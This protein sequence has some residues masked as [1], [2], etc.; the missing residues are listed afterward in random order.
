MRAPTDGACDVFDLHLRHFRPITILDCVDRTEQESGHC[1]DVAELRSE[2]AQVRRDL[3]AL[4]EGV[5]RIEG[6]LTGPWRPTN[7]SPAPASKTPAEAAA[8]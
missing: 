7:G 8:E 2:P 5:A 1:T 3:H 4:A 6:A